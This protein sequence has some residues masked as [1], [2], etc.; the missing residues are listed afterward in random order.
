MKIT[1]HDGNDIVVI[2]PADKLV[3][4]EVSQDGCT[5][6]GFA[7]DSSI[8]ETVILAASQCGAWSLPTEHWQAT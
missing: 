6:A 2:C 8:V 4:R 3:V 1:H 7:A 5:H